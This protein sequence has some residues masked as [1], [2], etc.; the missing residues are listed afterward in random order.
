M[1]KRMSIQDKFFI[2]A[3]CLGFVMVQLDITI[4]NVGLESLRK[5]YNARIQDL[6]WVINIYSLVFAALL[7]SSGKLGDRYGVRSVF[8]AG[9]VIFIISSLC[10]AFS[11]SLGW[12]NASRALQGFG[13]ALLV[14]GSLTLLRQ[15]FTDSGSRAFAIASWAA[16]GGFALAAGPVLGGSL[17]SL[18]GWKSIFLINIPVGL[19]SIFITIHYAPAGKRIPVRFNTQGQLL[20]ALSLG[21]L[22]FALTEAGHYGWKSGITLSALAAAI[23]AFGFYLINERNNVSPVILPSVL[24][25]KN[26]VYPVV[27]GF[28]CNLVFYGAVFIFSIYFQS[29]MKLTAFETGLA[30]V[31]MM[32]FNALVNLSSSKLA[33]RFGIRN[34]AVAGGIISFIGF[35]LLMLITNDWTVWQLFVPMMLLSAGTSLSVPGMANLIFVYSA[36]EEAGS[37]SALFSCARQMG[38]VFGVAIFGLLLSSAGSDDLIPGL[39]LIAG[40][41]MGLAFIWAAVSQF[42]LPVA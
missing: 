21:F 39:K 29:E 42:K 40:T 36:H 28:L 32:L 4:V 23:I 25:N 11:P 2:T 14:P 6:E 41:A 16:A 19:V 35:G 20:I 31:P 13:A 33:G 5:A 10:C 24:D 18:L 22:T 9:C 30:F 27:V 8:I 34:L 37:A 12:L 1:K 15:Y 7:L 17:I 38:G 26:I 3:I